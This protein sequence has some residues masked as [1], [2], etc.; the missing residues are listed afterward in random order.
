MSTNNSY[1]HTALP[2]TAVTINDAFWSPR[3]ETNRTVTIGY[4]YTART[5][6]ERNGTPEKLDEQREELTR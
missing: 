6:A 1:Q 3:V 5:I 2:F 4:D